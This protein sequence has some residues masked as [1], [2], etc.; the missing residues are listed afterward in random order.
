MVDWYTTTKFVHIM[1]VV[2]VGGMSAGS[3]FWVEFA[4][5]GE[6]EYFVLR[7]VRR[8]H[9][10]F[11]LPGLVLIPATGVAT[12]WVGGLPLTLGWIVVATVLWA[13]V[14]VAML[15]YAWVVTHQI[16]MLE[17]GD[18]EDGG[19]RRLALAGIVLGA[20]AGLVFAAIVYVM[21]AK[22]W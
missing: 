14:F 12:A 5:R 9:L 7:Q 10:R 1:L 4:A 8:F 16:R 17:D 11:V 13:V 21:I 2:L 19:Y 3:G 6:Y 15:A 18:A 20:G 22:P